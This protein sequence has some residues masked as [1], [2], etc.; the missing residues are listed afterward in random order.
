MS[1]VTVNTSDYEIRRA[2]EALMGGF[3]VALDSKRPAAWDQYGYDQKISFAKL[4]LAYE[5]NGA[6]FGAVHRILDKCWEA[7]PRIKSPA[8]DKETPWE[9]K[10]SDLMTAVGAWAKLA[11]F[12]RRNLIGRYSALI[13]R[14]ADNKD[15]S[16]ELGRGG[17]LVDLIPLDED[18]IRT[19]ANVEDRN[20]PEYGK[21]VMFEYRSKAESGDSWV[22]VHPSRVQFFAEGSVGDFE[23][24]VPLLRAGFNLLVDIEK[25]SGGGAESALKNSARTIVFEYNA[26]ANIESLDETG[27]KID[28]RGAHEELGRALN[29]NQD[30]TIT[31]QGGKASTL[32]TQIGKLGEQ[33]EISANLFAASV[34]LPF[35]ILFGQQTG[36]LASDQDSRDYAARCG[37]RRVKVLTPMLTEFVTRMQAAGIID[38][39]EFE[40]EWPPIDAPSDSDKLDLLN[41]MVVAMKGAFDAGL[42][43]PM[44]TLDELRKVAGFETINAKELDSVTPVEPADDGA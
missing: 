1:T 32:Q 12:D 39:G 42:G 27:K 20:S 26:D 34:Q 31:M 38:A 30:S 6:G 7:S 18:Q 15:L 3:V 35:T 5:R 22:D 29:R 4:K 33:F 25:L 21:P 16:M 17:K 37:S 14:V 13:Y 23:A 19:K 36:R 43:V 9:K 24:G 2:R 28:V 44:F 40:I 10:V 11:D 8:S 41:K